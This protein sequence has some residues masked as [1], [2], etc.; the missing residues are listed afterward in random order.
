MDWPS[1]AFLYE[2]YMFSLGLCGFPPGALLASHTPKNLL[3]RS[4]SYKFPMDVNVGVTVGENSCLSLCQPCD[5]LGN[6]PGY[7]LRCTSSD[8]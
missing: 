2:V 7:T 6:W 4:D 8:V 3:N 5:G 1:E